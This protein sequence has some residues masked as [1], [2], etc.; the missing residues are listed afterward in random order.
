MLLALGFSHTFRRTSRKIATQRPP[1]PRARE[2]RQCGVRRSSV[3]PRR[4]PILSPKRKQRGEKDTQNFPWVYRGTN[5]SGSRPVLSMWGAKQVS[6][7]P[8]G[9]PNRAALV[10]IVTVLDGL[11]SV[12]SIPQLSRE[13][14]TADR[15]IKLK[16][17][18]GQETTKAPR[19]GPMTEM[20]ADDRCV[21]TRQGKTVRD[22]H[23]VYSVGWCNGPPRGACF[24]TD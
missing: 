12:S 6:W 17:L 8:E 22:A 13:S 16:F 24:Q 4:A 1:A 11:R 23:P 15:L 18:G 7:R 3:C 19:D 14:G 2:T 9:S 5:Q 20:A 21:S 10:C